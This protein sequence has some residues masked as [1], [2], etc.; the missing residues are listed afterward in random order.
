MKRLGMKKPGLGWH[1]FRRLL[2]TW[3]DQAG[4]TGFTIQEQLG[5]A[6]LETTRL[7]VLGAVDKRQDLIEKMQAEFYREKGTVQ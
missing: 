3:M 4:A 6:S 5:H 7:Y 2:A 1:S